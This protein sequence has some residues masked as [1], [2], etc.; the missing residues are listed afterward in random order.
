MKFKKKRKKKKKRRFFERFSVGQ[1]V[2]YGGQNAQKRSLD[3][4]GVYRSNFQTV[5]VTILCFVW[6]W[7]KLVTFVARHSYSYDEAIKLHKSFQ[8]FNS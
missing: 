7:I 1:E 4:D 3:P 5:L 8:G 2:T 6:L